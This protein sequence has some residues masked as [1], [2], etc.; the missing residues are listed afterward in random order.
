MLRRRLLA[1]IGAAGALIGAVVLAMEWLPRPAV[2]QLGGYAQVTRLELAYVP[3]SDEVEARFHLAS[4]LAVN[5]TAISEAAAERLFQAAQ[6]LAAGKARLFVSAR[7]D[8][9]VSW[10]LSVP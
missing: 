8:R 3:A 7:N 4:G 5:E 9:V 1:R 10:H 2:A 6:V